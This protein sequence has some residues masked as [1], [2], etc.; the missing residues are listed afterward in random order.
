MSTKVHSDLDFQ[1][2]V[3]PTNIPTPLS[4]TDAANRQYVDDKFGALN[5]KDDV[6]CAPTGNVNI[7]SPGA[8]HDG[9]TI[10]AGDTNKRMLLRNQTDPKENG[11]YDWNGAAVPLTRCDDANLGAELNNAVVF[12]TEGT[13]NAGTRWRQITTNPTL[14]TSNIVFNSDDVA[15]PQATE[16]VSGKAEVA[17]QAET[18]AGTSDITIVTPLKLASWTGKAKRGSVAFGDGTATQFDFTH[19]LGTR[20][21]NVQVYRNSTPWDS[22]LCDISR[23]DA[24]TVRLNF[25]TAPASNAFRVVVIG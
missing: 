24:N 19:N 9:V 3:R 22:I 18:D 23:P 2:A 13:T 25:A 21:I 8:T 11:L 17:T 1:N 7:A 6:R 12:V 10:S 16:T 15:V 4:S 20:D 14:G 5:W